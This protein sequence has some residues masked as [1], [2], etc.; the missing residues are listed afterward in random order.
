MPL[1]H[2]TRAGLRQVC[3]P[4][5]TG[6]NKHYSNFQPH[7]SIDLMLRRGNPLDSKENLPKVR[8]SSEGKYLVTDMGVQPSVRTELRVSGWH[9]LF[10]PQKHCHRCQFNCFTPIDHGYHRLLPLREDTNY[11]QTYDL[12]VCIFRQWT[13]SHHSIPFCSN[14]CSDTSTDP[15]L[16]THG[17]IDEVLSTSKA[18]ISEDRLR[19][20]IIVTIVDINKHANSV[21]ALRF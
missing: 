7:T 14:W 2:C 8:A 15:G 10:V 4:A 5:R 9:S 6:S 18:R 3:A 1:A 13:T 11:G 16:T 20:S 21:F 19:L 12:T 17:V